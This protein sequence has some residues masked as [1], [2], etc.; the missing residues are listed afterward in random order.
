[1][2]INT[3]HI[4]FW[5]KKILFL[6]MLIVYSFI[7]NAQVKTSIDS[8]S[9][10]IGEELL[11]A[12]ETE[13]DSVAVVVFPEGQTFQPM[14]VIESYPVDTILNDVRLKL[15]KK[16]GI[17][18]FDSG[19]YTIPRQKVLVGDQTLYSDSVQ[20]TVRS[21]LVD[22]TK[23][24]LYDIKPLIAVEKQLSVWEKFWWGFVLLFLVIASGLYWFFFRKKVLTE[25][26]RIAALPPYKQAKL[27]LSKLDEQVYFENQKIKEYYSDLTFILRKYLNE[28]VYDQSLESTTDELVTRLNLLKDSKDVLIKKITIENIQEILKRADLVKFAKSK[29]DFEIARMD[30]QIIDKE[31]DHVKEGLPE[32]T[33]E[34]LLKDLEYQKEI[35][36]KQR[37]RKIKII[38][39]CFVGA[40][41]TFFVGF[42]IHSGFTTAKD[43]LLRHPS[44]LLLENKN[45]VR[46]EYGAP[47]I[48]VQTPEVLER[49]MP[50]KTDSLNPNFNT[51]IFSFK[52]SKI[53]LEITVKSSVLSSDDNPDK[54]SSEAI[55]LVGVAN[56]ELSLL[57]KKGAVN[58]IPRTEQFITPNGQEGL[59]TYGTTSLN[60]DTGEFAEGNFIILG[61]STPKVLQQLVLVWKSN[62]IYATEMA[63]RILNSV[64]LIKDNQE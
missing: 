61:F 55:D 9:I 51:K 7:G 44:K 60:F 17:T 12:I 24:K 2:T 25:E 58:L 46:S 26:E 38:G 45:W 62:D 47:G 56:K 57:E 19:A 49:Q 6:G 31:I 63:N 53:P 33:E 8:T 1:M 21:V 37:R 50:V 48:I 28:K 16:Y 42:G 41:I 39:L 14:E 20:I 35:E 23:Q 36:R 43:T 52:N 11:Y 54:S 30:K 15:I 22:T 34:E 64:E 10:K 18:Q 27:A 29:P 3:K 32:P 5:N 40:L 13:V 4:K 59:K